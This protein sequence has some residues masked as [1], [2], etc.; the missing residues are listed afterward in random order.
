MTVYKQREKDKEFKKHQSMF[1]NMT[2]KSTELQW[3]MFETRIRQ[4]IQELLEPLNSRQSEM[5]EQSIRQATEQTNARRR[6]E[7][8]ELV[9][10]KLMR[11]SGEFD[12]LKM[13][14]DRFSNEM[15]YQVQLIRNEV[16]AT[17]ETSANQDQ[18]VKQIRKSVEYV[19]SKTEELRQQLRETIEKAQ[20]MD[21]ES[22]AVFINIKKECI[23]T[24]EEFKRRRSEVDSFK[25]EAA[26]RQ[27]ALQ[28]AVAVLEG[29]VSELQHDT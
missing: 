21:S 1:K 27:A 14:Q 29:Q 17:T 15:K 23:A 22:R 5:N 4:T 19:T 8:L 25:T 26:L 16:T 18:R 20:D 2:D 10:T 13:H 6:I 12:E 7:E 3:F 11:Q 9:V 28:D 24:L